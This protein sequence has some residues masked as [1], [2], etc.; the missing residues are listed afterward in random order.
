MRL[1]KFAL[2]PAMFLLS[3]AAAQ[4]PSMDLIRAAARGDSVAVEDLLNNKYANVHAKTKNG[5]TALIGAAAL[6]H[7]P[8]VQILLKQ[9]PNPNAKD[10]NGRTALIE[11][12][13]QGNPDAVRAL[14]AETVDVNARDVNGRTALL[15][16]ASRGNS[17]A[18]ALLINR[19][20]RSE[21]EGQ[22]GSNGGH[23]SGEW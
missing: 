17:E 20:S 21:I 14:L 19:G 8:I 23:G 10:N 15:E 2:W 1:A 7:A 16:A 13:T 4:N 18:V 22:E 12:A 6:G 3:P 9:G 11:A 5:R